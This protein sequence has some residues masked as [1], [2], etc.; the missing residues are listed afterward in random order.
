MSV[1]HDIA[2]NALDGLTYED[3]TREHPEREQWLPKIA[4]YRLLYR[5]GE[6]FLR[7]AGETTVTRAQRSTTTLTAAYSDFMA[8]KGRRRRFLHQLEGEPDT[9]YY[10]R[11]ERAHYIGYLGAIVD[12]Y[13][14]WLFSQPPVIRPADGEHPDWW[15]DF[16]NGAAG[17]VDFQAFVRDQVRDC[18][19]A[20]KAGW[21]ISSPADTSERVQ[22]RAYA[23]EEMLDWQCDAQGELE[24]IVL[25]KCENRRS[26]PEGRVQV[27]TFTYVDRQKWRSWEAVRGNE[28]TQLEVIGDGVHGLGEVP[29]VMLEIPYG[30]WPS[31]KLASWQTDL[32]NKMSMLSYGQLVSC[33]LQ[34]FLKTNDDTSDAR[35]FG[36]G[37]LLKLKAGDGDQKP[38]E[39]GWA[40]PN[41]DPLRFC[42]EQ[43]KEQRDEG[44]RIV[45]QMSLAVDSQ[46]IGAIARSGASKI[47]DRRAS[48]IILSGCYGNVTREAM[49]KT[50]NL[51]SKIMGDNLE[52]QV[53][54]YDNFQVSSLDEELATA[55]LVAN[56]DIQSATFKKELQKNIA[57]GR[58]LGHLSEQTKKQ[59]EQEIEEA[60]DLAEEQRLTMREA[61]VEAI[62]NPEAED[63]GDKDADERN[64]EDAFAPAGR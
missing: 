46:A 41:V 37:I 53:D 30:L 63:P 21:L 28:A 8:L 25:K 3:L 59:I 24:W 44:Y 36:E 48:E 20:R 45:H 1:A 58:V 12:F 27:E 51:V 34:P 19:I 16:F 23:F 35:V 42:S 14:H 5:G 39:Y 18:L 32:F 2:P 64:P 43:L 9:K 17:N 49:V 62:A 15:L 7:A 4:D 29:F 10:S 40:S 56:F 13:V 50:L 22:L 33:F 54:G 31:N 55:A 52:W 61:Q 38:E 57:T 6:E 26:F 60:V 47:E 11:W